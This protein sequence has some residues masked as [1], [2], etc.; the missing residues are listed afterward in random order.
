MSVDVNPYAAPAVD[1]LPPPPRI[2]DSEPIPAPQNLRLFNFIIDNVVLYAVDVGAGFA[3]AI[4]AVAIGRE[5]SLILLDG[6]L[7]LAIGVALRL[8]Y[9]IALESLWGRTIGKL[10]A[11]T[12]VVNA[13]GLKP[14]FGQV[15]IRSLCRFIPFE[16]FSFL[17]RTARGWHDKLPNT[18]VVKAR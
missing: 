8:V 10:A 12:V 15:W 5:E 16:A 4:I 14:T 13:Q 7:G 17:G 1:P 3:I 6:P 2:A 9:Y 18:Y 11:G